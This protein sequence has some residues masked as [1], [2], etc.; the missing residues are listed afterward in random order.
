M[1]GAGGRLQTVNAL[2]KVRA[3]CR[4]FAETQLPRRLWAELSPGWWPGRTVLVRGRGQMP[5]FLDAASN[6]LGR[7]ALG[8]TQRLP[9]CASSARS[10]SAKWSS[11]RTRTGSAP[12]G[13]PK[14]SHRA[15]RR[16]RLSADA[17]EHAGTYDAVGIGADW[18]VEPLRRVRGVVRARG[19]WRA[20]GRQMDGTF[21][22]PMPFGG[23][24]T[25]P[26]TDK[27]FKT[28]MCTVGHWSALRGWNPSSDCSRVSRR[29][30]VPRRDR[31][32]RPSDE[33]RNEPRG[34]EP[35]TA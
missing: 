15:R 8:R 28:I 25:I 35:K 13:G 33:C 11:T 22:K 16:T 20:A 6:D 2:R 34:S 31:W 24:N 30:F 5:R 26:P 23:G 9:G 1:A 21:T 19:T 18:S 27:P 4:S 29:R 17:L 32:W 7:L 10:S 14:G 12:S 3:C